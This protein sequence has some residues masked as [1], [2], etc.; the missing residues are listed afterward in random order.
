MNNST[1]SS[2]AYSL[3]NFRL[4]RALNLDVRVLETRIKRQAKDGAFNYS[5]RPELI[6]VMVFCTDPLGGSTQR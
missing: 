4:D 5:I 6:M 2:S 3:K 1:V